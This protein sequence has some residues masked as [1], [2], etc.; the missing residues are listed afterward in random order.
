MVDRRDANMAMI[1]QAEEQQ[2]ATKE[3][4]FRIDRQLAETEEMETKH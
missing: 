3:T 1:Q 2:S 4:V